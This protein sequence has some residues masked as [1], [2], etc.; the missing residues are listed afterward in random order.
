MVLFYKYFLLLTVR[1][2]T[3][4]EDIALQEELCTY[5]RPH[6][7]DVISCL[8]FGGKWITSQPDLQ[9]IISFIVLSSLFSI[10]IYIYI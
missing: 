10:Y 9:V 7:N 5:P 6:K 1:M 2:F 4:E 8:G 3:N